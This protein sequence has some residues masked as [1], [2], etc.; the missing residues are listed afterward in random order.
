MQKTAWEFIKGIMATLTGYIAWYL[1]GFDSLLIALLV[2]IVADYLTGVI[3]A[4]IDKKLNSKIGFRG[5]AKKVMILLF[6]G[7]AAAL[8]TYVIQGNSPIREIVI[9]F[10]IANE[11]I[12]VV[13]NSAKIGL[14]VPQ[15]I[16]DVLAQLKGNEED[17]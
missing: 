7:L 1:G 3:L 14:P 5:I 2:F 12:S 4:I 17:K 15:K 6:V 8:D 16:I 9:A 13:E 10:Y 11:G